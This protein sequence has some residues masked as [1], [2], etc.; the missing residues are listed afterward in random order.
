MRQLQTDFT[1][2]GRLGGP[3]CEYV[4]QPLQ[5][6]EALASSIHPA[7]SKSDNEQICTAFQS[8]RAAM[9]GG[10]LLYQSRAF[11]AFRSE[12]FRK[13]ICGHV[14]Q[15]TG[16]AVRAHSE[17][18]GCNHSFYTP[19]PIRILENVMHKQSGLFGII[20]PVQQIDLEN[21]L[22]AGYKGDFKGRLSP[23]VYDAC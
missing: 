7:P 3:L 12:I 8:E 22:N 5:Y 10:K 4:C 21:T 19:N 18:E 1:Q 23:G 9:R 2:F 20:M 17:Q 11:T 6:A 14:Q 15:V 16:K 13:H